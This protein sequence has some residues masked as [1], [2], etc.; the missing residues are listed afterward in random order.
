MRRFLVDTPRQH[1][2]HTSASAGQRRLTSG[3]RQLLPALRLLG[4]PPEEDH[5]IILA[6]ERT[7]PGL[8]HPELFSSTTEYCSVDFADKAGRCHPSPRP[9]VY[10]A[11][12]PGEWGLLLSQL[13]LFRGGGDT[14]SRAN[15]LLIIDDVADPLY[16]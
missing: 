15:Q 3:S 10:G 5:V 2:R 6:S 1:S 4:D 7:K 16:M 13:V 12:D 11:D 14:T 9:C 8:P